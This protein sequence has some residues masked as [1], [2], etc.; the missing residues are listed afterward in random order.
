MEGG[1][2]YCHLSGA[3]TQIQRWIA[4]GALPREDIAREVYD[5]LARTVARSVCAGAKQTGVGQVLMA[6]GVASSPLFREMVTERVRK[7][8]R[9]LKVYFGR[10]EYSGDNAVG[11][12]LIGAQKLREQEAA[13]AQV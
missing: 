12:A 5:L 3:E 11:T 8:D 6:G 7:R 4:S 13:S 2:L 1:D 10:P 9:A